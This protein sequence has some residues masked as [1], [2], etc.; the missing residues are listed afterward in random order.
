MRRL[1]SP[2][3]DIHQ[4]DHN[5]SAHNDRGTHDNVPDHY[6]NHNHHNDCA[7]DY[8]DGRTQEPRRFGVVW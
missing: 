1:R 7:A 3:D 5:G 4:H 6:D 2:G 8:N